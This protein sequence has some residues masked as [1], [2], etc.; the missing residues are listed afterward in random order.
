MRYSKLGL[1]IAALLTLTV[2]RQASAQFSEWHNCQ[3]PT[4]TASPASNEVYVYA[5]GNYGGQCA[6]MYI[7]FYP[8]AGNQPG[9]FGVP[10]DSISSYKIGFLARMRAFADGPFQGSSIILSSSSPV[11]PTGWN[12]VIS[13]IRVEDGSRSV[14]CNDL[15]AGEFALFTGANLTGDCVVYKYP[16]IDGGSVS[17]QDPAHMG[18][19]NDYIKSVNG[20]PQISSPQC[21]GYPFLGSI[22]LFQNSNFS[23]TNVLY[24]NNNR[25]NDL[26]GFDNATS[27][28][29]ASTACNWPIY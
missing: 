25:Y 15:R 19:A 7:G 13:S 8:Y 11:M 10:N 1:A 22:S 6:A 12:D 21:Y 4:S 18:I 14:N 27:S 16:T 9:G 24:W 23:G 29:R 5:D 20:G 2:S 26:G 28:F 17:F 3:T